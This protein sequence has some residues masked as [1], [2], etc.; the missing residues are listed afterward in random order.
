MKLSLI[1]IAIILLSSACYSGLPKDSVQTSETGPTPEYDALVEW[2][3]IYVF[4]EFYPPN[5]NMIYGI[6]IFKEKDD[7]VAYINIDGHLTLN[8]LKTKVSGD[9]DTIELLFE[10]YLPDSINFGGEPYNEGDLLLRLKQSNKAILTE[11]GELKPIISGN[12]QEGTY[13]VKT[14]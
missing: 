7:Y 3:G 1:C 14:V 9:A 6:E 10:T 5:I 12:E 2:V 8:R 4:S 13:F 11:W